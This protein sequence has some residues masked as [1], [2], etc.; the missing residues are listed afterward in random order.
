[1]NEN[2]FKTFIEGNSLIV[3][4]TNVFLGL[5]KYSSYSSL[6]II[7]ILSSCIDRLWIPNQVYKGFERN[8]NSEISKIKKKYK[9]FEKDLINEVAKARE[10]IINRINESK[11][12]QYSNCDVLERKMESHIANL[13]SEI[14]KY[15]E[16]LG[17]E[18]ISIGSE[19]VIEINIYKI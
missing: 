11:K 15:K 7:K 1:M 18:Y 16:E 17:V 10:K 14:E 13:I 5:Y 2:E 9:N 3:L 6:N 8:E 19:K 4:D 12:L